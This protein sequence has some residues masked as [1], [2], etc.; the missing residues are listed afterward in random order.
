MTHKKIVVKEAKKK[1]PKPRPYLSI[2][3]ETSGLDPKNGVILEI[4]AI[5]DDLESPINKL[6]HFHRVI[7]YDPNQVIK[8]MPFAL[9]M[10]QNIL[11][12]SCGIDKSVAPIDYPENIAIEWY[13]FICGLK[14][15]GRITVAGKNVAG[16]DI[17]W[18]K[19]HKF[20]TSCFKHRVLDPGPMFLQ[21]FG[22]VPNLKEIKLLMGLKDEVSHRAL[23][24]ALDV[25]KAIRFKL[26][27]KA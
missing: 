9:Q 6:M 26:G 4:A 21:E 23:D 5:F 2:D 10:N 12:E 18:L 15:N 13:K 14:Q 3:L 22:Y 8:G 20:A 1:Y 11:R 16:F 19:E 25:V 24:D 27:V 17:P 7:Q